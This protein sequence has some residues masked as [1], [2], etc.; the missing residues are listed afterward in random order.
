MKKLTL[1]K[2]SAM[3]LEKAN[4]K[5]ALSLFYSTQAP[6][7]KRKTQMQIA[8]FLIENKIE[9]FTFDLKSANWFQY[10]TNVGA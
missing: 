6:K 9:N 8:K 3:R 10:N 2:E 4:R 7:P 1:N 5:I